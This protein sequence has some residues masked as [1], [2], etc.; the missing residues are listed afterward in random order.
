V[1]VSGGDGETAGTEGS[2]AER[3]AIRARESGRRDSTREELRGR[4]Q[5]VVG[6][7]IEVLNASKLKSCVL[8]E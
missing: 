2:R 1:A 7:K 8:I 4:V 5:K 3:E 6:I